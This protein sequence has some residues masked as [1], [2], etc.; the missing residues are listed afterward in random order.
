M[1][2]TKTIYSDETILR[3]LLMRNFQILG[4]E[5]VDDERTAIKRNAFASAQNLTRV[6][7]PNLKVIPST[8]FKNASIDTLDLNWNEITD[9]GI[10]AFN[11]GV[12][13][14][15]ALS[16]PKCVRIGDGAFANNASLASVS[17]PLWTGTLTPDGSVAILESGMFKGC[18]ALTG[19]GIN[20][21]EMT[22]MPTLIF[23]GC[24]SLQEVTFDKVT[25]IGSSAFYGC[26]NLRKLRFNGAVRTIGASMLNGCTN[27]EALIFTGITSVPSLQSSSLSSSGIASG[28]GYIYVPS[29]ML[30]SVKAANNW[31]TYQDIIRACEDY[32]SIV[33]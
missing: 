3:A 13:S 29:A 4:G 12:G 10:E 22:S 8:C 17:I 23:R 16:L 21:P 32:P 2:N 14:I 31:K 27:M 30:A 9:V 20:L 15:T 18:T 6:S 5:F 26:T 33:D 19:A 1:A 24:T 28:K 25:T 7:L 11:G